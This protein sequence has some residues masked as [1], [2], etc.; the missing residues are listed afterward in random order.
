M[1][2]SDCAFQDCYSAVSPLQDKFLPSHGNGEVPVFKKLPY[3]PC[4]R[5]FLDGADVTCCRFLNMS[6]NHVQ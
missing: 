6:N 5:L 2:H 1:I 4:Y 3:M